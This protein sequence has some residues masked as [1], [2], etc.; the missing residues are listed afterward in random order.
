MTERAELD[1]AT[2]HADQNKEAMMDKVAQLAH[3]IASKSPISVRGT[4]EVLQYSRD[5]SVDDGLQFMSV[6]NSAFLLSNDLMEAFQAS[7]QRRKAE[8][9]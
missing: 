3:L 7:M 4:K 6:W 2:R 1:R 5:H 8:F 9:K